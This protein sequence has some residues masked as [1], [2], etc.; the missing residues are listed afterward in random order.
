MGEN[1]SSANKSL[2]ADLKMLNSQFAPAPAV[3]LDTSLL[4]R[5]GD[6][7]DPPSGMDRMSAWSRGL[8]K[9]PKSSLA[10]VASLV[11]PAFA[12]GESARMFR[13]TFRAAL[14][15]IWIVGM[16]TFCEEIELMIVGQG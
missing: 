5:L 2:S 13:L 16:G 1:P 12:S 8:L 14:S 15:V 11:S 4:K 7:K 10:V 9:S 6:V 3:R